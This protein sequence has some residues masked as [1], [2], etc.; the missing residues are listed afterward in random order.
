MPN[1]CSFEMKVIG[2]EKNLDE[3]YKVLKADYHVG[4][5]DNPVHMYRIFEVD[6]YD[7]EN[8]ENELC[9]AYFYGQCAW[10]IYTCMTDGGYYADYLNRD[11]NA[12]T[13]KELS[14]K[15]DLIIEANSVEEGMEFQEHY[16]Y[17]NG[18]TL[19]NEST[20]IFTLC[21]DDIESECNKENYKDVILSKVKEN[22]IKVDSKIKQQ[23]DS[24]DYEDFKSGTWFI[25]GG[26]TD[27]RYHFDWTI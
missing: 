23:I 13:L 6:R 8:L 9:A 12:T 18:E 7:F 15:L 5:K 19:T 11:W 14:K 24:I 26:Y 2:T 3:F 16:I 17:R 27:I 22:K 4:N 10:S 25:F 1:L 20:D 21:Y